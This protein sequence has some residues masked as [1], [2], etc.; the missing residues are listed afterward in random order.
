MEWNR[1]SV[2]FT[3][4][5]KVPAKINIGIATMVMEFMEE[6]IFWII[7]LMFNPIDKK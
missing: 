2:R 6:P 4:F 3:L 5:I 1:E 7:T